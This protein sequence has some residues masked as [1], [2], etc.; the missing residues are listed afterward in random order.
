MATWASD[1]VAVCAKNYD[2]SNQ[3]LIPDGAG[4]VILAWSDNRNGIGDI[5]AARVRNGVAMWTTNGVSLC[6]APDWQLTPAI[7]PDG[8]GGAIVTWSDRRSG[9]S[10]DIYA[11][12]VDASGSRLWAT[13]GVVLCSAV[14]NQTRPQAV[15]DGVGGVIVTWADT[16]VA[17]PSAS[18]IYAQR[19][20][21]S[22]ATLW[23]TDGEP[24]CVATGSQDPPVV[25]TDGAGG[26][27]IAWSDGRTGGIHDVYAQRV[28]AS[29]APL[30]ALDGEAICVASGNQYSPVIT[31]DAVGGAIIAWQ[32][33]RGGVRGDIY[34]Q[35]VSAFGAVQWTDNGQAVSADD[36]TQASVVITSDDA[37]GA[38]VVWTDHRTG[39]DT[40]IFAQRL[41]A[42]GV[43]QWTVD[44]LAICTAVESQAY[45]AIAADGSGGAVVAWE[46]ER[47]GPGIKDIYALRL[48]P[49]GPIPTGIR[50]WPR[51]TLALSPSFPN[52]FSRSTA[53]VLTV[54]AESNVEIDVF[55]VSGR[56]VRSL[57]LHSQGAEQ[58]EIEFDGLDD[59]GRMLPSGVYFCRVTTGSGMVTRKMVITR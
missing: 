36:S 29:G 47:L 6:I 4:G 25:V 12:R 50:D 31:A 55:D 9:T 7:A 3:A 48:G 53:M 34:A 45:P 32:D 42:L 46:D 28:D 43:P 18:D 20:D 10:Y 44:G 1:G 16:R 27:T 13:S 26:A 30:W 40:D 22:G 23:T 39:D 59:E 14:G 37:G 51:S 33:Y 41:D 35:R 52:P 56:R 5:Y 57:S 19:V 2:Q 38:F 24:I 49:D 15:T 8:A 11:Q 17:G 58:R 21:E 54:S